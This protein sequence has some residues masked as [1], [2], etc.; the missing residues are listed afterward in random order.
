MAEKVF[1]VQT[2]ERDVQFPGSGSVRYS[3]IRLSDGKVFHYDVPPARVDSLCQEMN[4]K[5][6]QQAPA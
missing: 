1:V 3:I 6:A 4:R 5:V 2:Q